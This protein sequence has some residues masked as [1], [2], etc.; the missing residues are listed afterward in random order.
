MKLRPLAEFGDNIK[1]YIEHVEQY[2]RYMNLKKEM[3]Q[4]KRNLS[5][6]ELLPEPALESKYQPRSKIKS[7]PASESEPFV[8]MFPE[9]VTGSY[10]LIKEPVPDIVLD[11]PLDLLALEYVSPKMNDHTEGKQS[12][13]CPQC[14]HNCTTMSKMSAHME[15]LHKIGVYCLECEKC[16]PSQK[17][18]QHHVQD[19][20][21]GWKMKCELC[22][23]GFKLKKALK[24][25][26]KN[27]GVLEKIICD[28]STGRF[29]CGMCNTSFA[30]RHDLRKH[31]R[32]TCQGNK[33]E[34][35]CGFQGCIFSSYTMKEMKGHKQVAH[36]GLNS[37]GCD[38]C[39]HA[40]PKHKLMMQH[41]RRMHRSIFSC[42]GCGKEF[43][44]NDNLKKHKKACDIF[45]DEPWDQLSLQQKKRRA[46]A[47]LAL[48][49]GGLEKSEMYIG[50]GNLERDSLVQEPLTDVSE[51]LPRP[52]SSFEF[53]SDDSNSPAKSQSSHKDSFPELSQPD[54]LL[55]VT[56]GQEYTTIKDPVLRTCPKGSDDEYLDHIKNENPESHMMDLMPET[57]RG[58]EIPLEPG[59]LLEE[60]KE[61]KEELGEILYKLEDSRKEISEPKNKVHEWPNAR[62][63]GFNENKVCGILGCIFSCPSR[64]DMMSHKQKAHTGLKVFICDKCDH[65]CLKNKGLLQH[66]ARFHK[67]KVFC[68]R[69]T[70]GS[71]GCGKKFK[72]SDHLSKHFRFCGIPLLKPWDHLSLA[73]K[74]RRAKAEL[75][76]SEVELDM[77]QNYIVQ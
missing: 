43:G 2:R 61:N 65:V 75:A 31:C 25:H 28:P 27:C 44:R 72:R 45:F 71:S 34:D 57:G 35:I 62:S 7:E 1:G 17:Q 64:K 38:K 15:A 50:Q 76:D 30:R 70:N 10:V 66:K 69:G 59:E 21:C 29:N 58:I 60:H 3:E 51:P 52:E 11:P 41:K 77:S 55:D 46:R 74:R 47:E 4:I 36:K 12:F 8:Q 48:S 42:S 39:D 54:L 56:S 23:Q 6:Q 24:V 26:M 13:V 63:T 5:V 53:E 19:K 37:F 67:D 40:F 49:R 33:E 22:S 68:C 20:N 73:Q 9:P 18:L 16:F 14:N 32:K